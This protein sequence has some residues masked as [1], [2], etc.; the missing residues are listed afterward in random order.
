MKRNT[1]IRNRFPGYYNHLILIECLKRMTPRPSK[2]RVAADLE[3]NSETV[4][5]VFRGTASQKQVWP[6]AEY[7]HVDWAKLHDLA[8]APSQ[9]RRALLNGNAR[10]AR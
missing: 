4:R 3:M 9:Y 6:V 2:R 10:S 1:D 5:R 7:F 8:I